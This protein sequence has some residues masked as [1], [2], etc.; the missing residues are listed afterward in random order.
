MSTVLL[1]TVLSFRCASKLSLVRIASSRLNWMQRVTNISKRSSRSISKW[2]ERD[3]LIQKRLVEE[4]IREQSYGGIDSSHCVSLCCRSSRV[5]PVSVDLS[6]L[7]HSISHASTTIVI[8][9]DSFV[10]FLDHIENAEWINQLIWLQAASQATNFFCQNCLERQKVR[11]SLWNRD[12]V[13]MI[14]R[15]WWHHS[16]LMERGL[17]GEW[18]CIQC[19]HQ[20]VKRLIRRKR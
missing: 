14:D 10:I 18:S 1:P 7:L 6:L 15:L 12:R 2:P 8:R 16:H 4:G 3:S 13:C 20:P 9:S 11:V 17:W 19:N 5:V